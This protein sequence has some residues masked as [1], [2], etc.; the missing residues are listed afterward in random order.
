MT[1]VPSAVATDPMQAMSASNQIPQSMG[2]GI[3]GG[4]VSGA[5][6]AGPVGAVVGAIGGMIG[7]IG[8]VESAKAQTQA[9]IEQVNNNIAALMREK[10]YNV[11]NYQQFIADQLASNKMSFYASGLDYSSGTA[12]DV[13]MANKAASTA[14]MNM[15]VQ[16]YDTQIKNLKTQRAELEKQKQSAWTNFF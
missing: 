13:I 3:V 4:A 5:M 1:P 9:Q 16:N 10:S 6:I 2:G 15:M 14:D 11:Q 8:R 7:G 12:R